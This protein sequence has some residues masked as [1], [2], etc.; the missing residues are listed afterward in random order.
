MCKG[1]LCVVLVEET[2]PALG[3]PVLLCVYPSVN[4]GVV[5]VGKDLEDP[6]AQHLHVHHSECTHVPHPLS[7]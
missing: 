7:F 6:Q 4:H 2:A 1:F 5:E 3:S